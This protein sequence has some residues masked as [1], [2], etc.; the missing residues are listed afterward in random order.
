MS[1]GYVVCVGRST[2]VYWVPHGSSVYRA[3]REAVT[4]SDRLNLSRVMPA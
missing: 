1:R 4:A 2:Q 3:E